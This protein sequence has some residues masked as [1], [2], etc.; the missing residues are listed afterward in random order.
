SVCVDRASVSHTVL[1]E[2][3][4]LVDVSALPWP[5][6]SRWLAACAASAV[7]A[8]GPH[9]PGGRPLRLVDGLLYLARY[10]GEEELVRR[11]LTE[12][13]AAAPPEVDVPRLRA[14]L[15]RHFSAPGSERQRLAAAVSV[16]RRVTVLAR[17]PRT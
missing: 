9:E 7:V 12:R 11:S 1:G 15:E 3:D 8:D 6:P 17:G 13:A 14:G 5:D 10:W 4:E 2:G 16:L